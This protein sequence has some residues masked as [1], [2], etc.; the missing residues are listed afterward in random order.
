MRDSV[1]IKV[2]KQRLLGNCL[3]IY[4]LLKGEKQHRTTDFQIQLIRDERENVFNCTCL[5]FEQHKHGEKKTTIVLRICDSSFVHCYGKQK[6]L[7]I[8]EKKRYSGKP[9]TVTSD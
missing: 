2:I 4:C 3:K 9:F 5:R 7:R 1:I 8:V 6:S